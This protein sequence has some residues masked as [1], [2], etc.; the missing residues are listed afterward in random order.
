M[1]DATKRDYYDV[2][3][4]A[5]SA[6][7]AEIK[8]AYRKLA[9]KYHPDKNPGDQ[10]AENLF[11]EAAEAYEIL[12]SAEKRARYDRHGHAGVHAREF[13]SASDVMSS[14]GD[15]F[16]ALFG[17][18][19]GRGGVARGASMRVNVDVS[20]DEMAEG[21]EKTVVV[22]RAVR[23][24][25]C[26]GQ[27]SS[28][29]RA[30]VRCATCAGQGAVMRSQ[31]FFSVQTDCPACHGTGHRVESPCASCQ[32]EGRVPGKREIS[33]RV[34]KGV[35][36]GVAL[37]VTGEG[38]PGPRGGPPGD[39]HVRLHIEDHPFFVRSPENP[40]DLVINVPVP[41]SIAWLGG[42]VEVPTLEGT[43][44]LQMDAG[45]APDTL[46][47]I[48]GAGLPRFQQG[49]RGRVWARI[50]YDVP[51]KPSRRLK[52][53]LEALREVE[54][55]EPGPLRRTYDDQTRRHKVQREKKS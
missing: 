37:R 2:L 8:R 1:P 33:I 39:L 16:E 40:A 34:P 35:Y 12:S 21:A 18:Q 36:D 10:E 19:T 9:L 52:K 51:K 48:R 43:T 32:G 49:G 47:P 42:E 24:D 25:R 15:I 6:S 41:V 55:G 26:K 53:A 46:I 38:E 17:R 30:P 13:H 22:R 29:G 5:R 28:D 31:G 50:L 54:A 23:C 20:F 14:F 7:D 11:K 45:T 4:V 3:G 27:G 44:T